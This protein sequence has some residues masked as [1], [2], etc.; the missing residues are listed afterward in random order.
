MTG[1]EAVAYIHAYGWESHAP[2]LDRIRKLLRRLGDPQRELKF[3]HVAGTNGKGSV[4]ACLASVLE[5]AGYRVGL[6]TSP[7]LERFEERIRVNGAEI[8]GEK[9]GAL[10]DRI[11]PAAGAMAEHPTE[12]ELITAAAFLHFRQEDCEIVVLETGLGG[13][14][15]A[16][17]VIE[18]PELAVLTA[19]GV[20]HAALLGSTLTEIAAAKAGI[21]KPGGDV[22]S[23]GGCPEADQVFRRVCRER[24]AA[25][26]EL[27]LRRLRVRKRD[28]EGMALDFGPWEGLTLPL[29]G[30]YQ[31][32]NAAL[33]LMALER[34]GEKGWRISEEAVRQGLAAVRWPGRFEVLGRE[35]LFILD[36]AHNAHGMRAAVESLKTLAPGRRLVFLMGILADKDVGEMLDLLAPLAKQVLTLRPDS[37]RA[38][39]PAALCA[40]LA[41]RGVE[42]RVCGSAAEGVA[43]AKEAAGRQ[44][45]V[46][47]LGSLYLAGAVRTAYFQ[48]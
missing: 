32:E 47:A 33:A 43:A 9:L 48:S 15:D 31:A 46:C 40:A 21:I 34:L 27:D 5:A 12:F 7:H 36:G 10:L 41:E 11:R 17:N 29:A 37:P 3:I 35:P 1:E 38:M 25:L 16:S 8:S 24:G 2:G 42:A 30:T 20:D 22:V 6:N 14:L 28:L 13:A 39:D 23:R 19:M 44:G 18:V 4:C 45:A 26:R